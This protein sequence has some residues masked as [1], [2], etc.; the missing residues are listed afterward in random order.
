MAHVNIP[1]YIPLH[2]YCDEE[3]L[4]ALLQFGWL[5]HDPQSDLKERLE[6]ELTIEQRKA[7]KEIAVVAQEALDRLEEQKK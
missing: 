2:Q 7:I 3:A 5:V 1:K 6:L 4:N